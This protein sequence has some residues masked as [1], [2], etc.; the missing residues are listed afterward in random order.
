MNKRLAFL[1]ALAGGA[2]VG[3]LYWSQP[4]LDFIARDLQTG[5]AHAGWLVTATQVGY[6]IGVLLFV[7][8]GDMLNRRI[9]VPIAL[10]CAAAAL[11]ASAVAPTFAVLLVT[12]SLVGLTT[13][14]GQILVPLA[15]DLADDGNRGRIVGTVV[16]GILIGILV[17][18]TVSGLV[19]GAAGWRAIYFAAAG[20]AVVLAVLLWIAIPTLPARATMRYPAL[21]GSVFAIVRRERTVRWNLVLGGTSFAVF[22]MFWTAL[23]FLLSAPP[24]SFPVSII[25]LFGL[26]GLAGAAAAQRVG[27]LSDRGLGLPTIG[28]AWALI[29]VAFVVAGIGQR[30]VAVIIVAILLLDVAIQGHNITV[31]SRMFLIDP[32]ARSRLNTAFVTNNFIWGAVGSGLASFLWTQGGWTAVMVAAAALS[33]F[34]LTVWF[35]IRRSALRLPHER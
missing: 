8:L 15:G 12:L 6:A 19:A 31:Q 28:G 21:I 18:R 2:A 32:Q 11:L 4:L 24:F 9:L 17:S 23:T 25:G 20:L 16:S 27:R 10:L 35:I 29:L 34:A 14:S 3:N 7:P 22:T 1:F 26:V 30:S 33:G 13:I 5:T